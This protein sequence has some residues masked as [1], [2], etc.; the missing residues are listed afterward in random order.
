MQEFTNVRAGEWT[1][2]RNTEASINNFELSK[3]LMVI[4]RFKTINESH[5]ALVFIS[6]KGIELYV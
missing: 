3:I 4:R 6:L 1:V 2:S 5:F